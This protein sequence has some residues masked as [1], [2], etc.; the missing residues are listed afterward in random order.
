VVRRTGGAEVPRSRPGFFE[1]ATTTSGTP[2]SPTAAVGDGGELGDSL[3]TR[4]RSAWL[5]TSGEVIRNGDTALVV[6]GRHARKVRYAR[7]EPNGR[8]PHPRRYAVYQNFLERFGPAVYRGRG[9]SELSRTVRA[10]PFETPGG[11]LFLHE[12]GAR[13][14]G[15]QPLAD[16][17]FRGP[18]RGPVRFRICEGGG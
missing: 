12:R 7:V 14:R 15:I 3:R 18:R 6:G 16:D 1:A 10:G 9:S 2:P 4:P 17:R 8:N 5:L 13:Q 11:P